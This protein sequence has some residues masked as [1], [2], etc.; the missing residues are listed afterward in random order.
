MPDPP[1]P[2]E[3]GPGSAPRTRDVGRATRGSRKIIML[4]SSAHATACIYREAELFDALYKCLDPCLELLNILHTVIGLNPERGDS[5]IL[6][7]LLYGQG[8]Y[9]IRLAEL[10]TVMNHAIQR[11][12]PCTSASHGRA[13][14]D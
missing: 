13:G 12:N 10:E 5:V 11:C 4:A 3:P 14:R 6:E 9:L 8:L 1:M 2:T 7:F